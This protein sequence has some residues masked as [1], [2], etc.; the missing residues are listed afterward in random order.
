[1]QTSNSLVIIG[2]YCLPGCGC[3]G[4]NAASCISAAGACRS[5]ALMVRPCVANQLPSSPLEESAELRPLCRAVAEAEPVLLL[6]VPV[7]HESPLS[8]LSHT[9]VHQETQECVILKP[10][11]D[12]SVR[13]T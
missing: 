3:L 5:C 6:L 4:S 8:A 12:S 13:C 2:T 1:M 10:P 9:Q 11:C 7:L